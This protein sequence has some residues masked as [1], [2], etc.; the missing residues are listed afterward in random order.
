[1]IDL[2]I[3]DR[4]IQVKE[5]TTI[6]EATEEL[7]IKIPTLCYHK[8]LTPYGACRLCLVEVSRGNRSRIQASCLYPI[9]ED[10]IVH[11]D[12]ERVIKTRKIMIELLL[13]RCP[14]S[15]EIKELA[16]E[17]GVKES[18]FPKKNEDCILCGLC[19]RMCRERMG[20]SVI[21][22]AQRGNKRKIIPPFDKTSA[23]CLGCGA[24]EFIC[25]TGS[26]KAKNNCSEQIK[27]FPSEFDW[28]VGTRPVVNISYPQAVPNTAVIDE[29]CC[30]Q[31]N[32]GACQIC[33]EVCGPEA[34][35]FNQ[36]ERTEEIRVGAV[37]VGAGY[38]RFN[39]LGRL[40]YGYGE[41]PNVLT[42]PEFER[43]LSASGP[44]RGHLVRPSDKKEQIGRSS[45]RGRGA[46][47]TR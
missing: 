5:G 34:I 6:L 24:C 32:R 35:D 7:G 8:D 45:G 16:E 20:A 40:E 2:T 1:M 38:D 14:D 31:L 23:I 27:A 28:G 15:E 46:I 37:I 41:Y 13:A 18:R 39:P 17:L 4:Q 25:P 26:M 33:K 22:F 42:S 29:K 36:K 19:V 11:T 47:P 3:N 21:G 43:I 10:L 30:I 12:T 44:F 9:Q